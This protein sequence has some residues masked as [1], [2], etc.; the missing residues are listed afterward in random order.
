MIV[1]LQHKGGRVRSGRY[2]EIVTQLEFQAP[3]TRQPEWPDPERLIAVADAGEK[4]AP[5]DPRAKFYRGL[6]LILRKEKPE[7][8]ERLLREYLKRAPIRSSYPRPSTVYEWLGRLFENQN[9]PKA[10]EKEYRAAVN[11]DAKNKNAR[12]GLKRVEKK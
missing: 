5:A 3:A 6:G 7:E 9:Q 8:A 10:A 4:V 12:E 1:P 2:G 11:L